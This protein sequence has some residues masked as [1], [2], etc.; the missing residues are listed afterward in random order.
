M[1][2]I[3]ELLPKIMA[4]VGP[5]AK[6]QTNLFQKYKFRGIDDIYDAVQHILAK[7]GV[8]CLPSVV[9][10]VRH[11]RNSKDGGLLTFTCLTV[12]YTFYALDG[13][14]VVARTMGE[15]MD[16]SDKSTN[17]AM[18]SAQKYAL[19][20][21]LC[22]PTSEAK[23]SESESPEALG[24]GN[25]TV[26]KRTNSS[27]NLTEQ[28]NSTSNEDWENVITIGEQNK[29]PR[30][31]MKFWIKE[32]HKKKAAIEVYQLALDRFSKLNE[33]AEDAHAN[34]V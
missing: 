10:S 17:K 19:I 4:E 12:D 32:Q 31:Y 15:A 21:S 30:A 6:N 14:F 8:S 9:D 25:N 13:S 24:R 27:H 5:V 3:H 26:P 29:W 7:H 11:E 20:Q 18:S 34:A 2:L 33:I 23:D 1:A 16:S 28:T 22:L